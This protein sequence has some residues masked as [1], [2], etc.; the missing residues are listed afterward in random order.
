MKSPLDQF[1]SALA[2]LT[3]TADALERYQKEDAHDEQ[4][5]RSHAELVAPAAR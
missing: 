2:D 1:E 5:G 3:R 4:D